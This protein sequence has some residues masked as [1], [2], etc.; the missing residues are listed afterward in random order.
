M[1]SV[2]TIRVSKTFLCQRGEPSRAGSRRVQRALLFLKAIS[3][4]DL[5][6]EKQAF[7]GIFRGHGNVGFLGLAFL[8]L[9]MMKTMVS[10]W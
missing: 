4:R 8:D 7:R 10:H 9:E 5:G 2:H 6:L 3:L 1:A